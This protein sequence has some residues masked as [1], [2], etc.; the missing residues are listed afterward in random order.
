M[1]V[2]EYRNIYENEDQ[3]FFYRANHDLFLSFVS[4]FRT[5][6]KRRLKILDAGCGTGLLAK[7]LEK[8]GEVVGVD[9]SPQALFYSKKRGIKVKRASVNKL[10]FQAKTFDIV[11]SMDVLYHRQVNDKKALI[12]FWRVLKP[13]GLLLIR[14]PAHPLLFSSHDRFVHARQRYVK[15]ELMIKL[16]E[17][18]FIIQK[19]T[20][21]NSV[22]FAPAL[23]KVGFEKIKYPNTS[24]SAVAS[25]P[26]FVNQ[27][28]TNLLKAENFFAKHFF[29]P[30]GIG[31]FA[32]AKK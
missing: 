12:E 32:V 9:I 6:I 8:F 14:V 17:A 11:L 19:I 30:F 23:F 27:I 5:K 25:I 2:A 10:P 1:E 24:A 16:K 21:V 7:K 29:L 15:R 26:N 22:L 31:L 13:G 4:P 3:H 20:Y 18:G 28:L